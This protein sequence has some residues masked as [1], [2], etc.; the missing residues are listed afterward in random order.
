M[1]LLCPNFNPVNNS[2]PYTFKGNK[3]WSR[4]LWIVKEIP[5]YNRFYYIKET[6][7]S[8]LKGMLSFNKPNFCKINK[9]LMGRSLSKLTNYK[10]VE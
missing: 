7:K 8:K 10:P 3:I 6:C 5:D 9:L 2:P 4:K 1:N